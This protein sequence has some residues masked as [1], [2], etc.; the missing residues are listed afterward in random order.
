MWLLVRFALPEGFDTI[1][2]LCISSH[3]VGFIISILI[4]SDKWFDVTEDIAY[5]LIF[6]QVYCTIV[7]PSPRQQLVFGL[8][9][10]LFSTILIPC[11]ATVT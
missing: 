8:A 4:N 9:G 3:W 11:T 7:D 1:A 10:T 2:L 5:A 6:C